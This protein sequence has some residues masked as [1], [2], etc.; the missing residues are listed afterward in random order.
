MVKNLWMILVVCALAIGCAGSPVGECLE[1]AEGL[2]KVKCGALVL[3][4]LAPVLP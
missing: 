2:G 4:V 1:E 3:P